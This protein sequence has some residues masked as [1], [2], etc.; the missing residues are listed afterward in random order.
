MRMLIAALTIAGAVFLGILAYFT[1]NP[2]HGGGHR[3][4]HP[5]WAV[6]GGDRREGRRAILL[7]GCYACHVVSGI[8][9]ATGRVGPKL[10]EIDRQIYIGGVLTN[11]PGNMIDWIQDPPRFSPETA[12]PDLN[13]SEQDARNITAY[14]F[15]NP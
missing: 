3:R 7:Y 15:Q 14:L 8:R 4:D 11:S 10:E 5:V 1:L 2:W 12:M 13:V 9:E 6:H